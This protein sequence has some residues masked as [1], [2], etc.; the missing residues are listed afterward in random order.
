MQLQDRLL[1]ELQH[2]DLQRIG[3]AL[4]SFGISQLREMS[5]MLH[6]LTDNDMEEQSEFLRQVSLTPFQV[7][8]LRLWKV[9]LE[10][11]ASFA[12]VDLTL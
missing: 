5:K 6:T 1:H 12:V 9:E 8:N 3:P 7:R 2:R 10:P 4:C 11:K